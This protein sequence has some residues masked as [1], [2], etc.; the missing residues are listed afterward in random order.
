MNGLSY[1]EHKCNP[2]I[3][4]AIVDLNHSRESLFV[5]YG[6]RKFGAKENESTTR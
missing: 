6:L 2:D 3:A 5:E 4:N 1:P